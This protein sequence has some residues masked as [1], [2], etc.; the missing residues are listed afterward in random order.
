MALAGWQA[1][2][3]VQTIRQKER[4]FLMR[5]VEPYRERLALK[6][7]KTEPGRRIGFFELDFYRRA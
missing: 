1:A 3:D 6:E 7:Y 2:R 4:Y 5:I